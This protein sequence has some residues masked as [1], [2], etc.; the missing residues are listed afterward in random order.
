MTGDRIKA[1]AK[2]WA[3]HMEA[4]FPAG[5]RG[6]DIA[7]IEMV[8]FDSDAAGCLS[9]WLNNGGKFD[10]WRWDVLAECEQDL[11][12]VIPQLAGYEASYY[13]R[14]LDMTVPVLDLPDALA[15]GTPSD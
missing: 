9:T 12:R 6:V 15:P 3:A 4:A 11:T 13:Q 8:M 14:L 7:G 2:L 10:D 1:V 5:L